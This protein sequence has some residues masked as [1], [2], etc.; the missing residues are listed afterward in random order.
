MLKKL[1]PIATILYSLALITASL[2][3]LGR[4]PDLGISFADKIF[5][6]FAY[7]VLTVLW[8]YTFLYT[9]RYEFK[10]AIRFAAILAII[11][12]IIIEV[13]QGSVTVSRSLDVYDAI[14]N[15]LGAVLASVILWMK[16]NLGVK[17]V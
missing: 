2:I 15:T 14:A 11:F 6:F 16:S 4:V 17:N 9:Y 5:H 7:F 13:L 10:K 12:G 3:K 8:F 1:V